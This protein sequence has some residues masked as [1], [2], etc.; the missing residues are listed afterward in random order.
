MNHKA[1]EGNGHGL[2]QDN[3]IY[4]SG[5]FERKHD[6]LHGGPS[7]YEGTHFT[8]VLSTLFN[9]SVNLK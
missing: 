6:T 9:R 7:L 3:G 5:V 8:T 1:G 2:I 4:L